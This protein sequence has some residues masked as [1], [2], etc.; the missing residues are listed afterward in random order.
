MI[1]F[2]I[3]PYLTSSQ[4]KGELLSIVVASL[5]SR[6]TDRI[7][8]E[9]INHDFDKRKQLLDLFQTV[10]DSCNYIKHHDLS[11][12][13]EQYQGGYVIEELSRGAS[14]VNIPSN[15]RKLLVDFLKF[16]DYI[17]E[18]V[19]LTF[20]SPTELH[21]KKTKNNTDYLVRSILRECDVIKYE[22]LNNTT[23]I[24]KIGELK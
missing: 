5:F 17:G 2:K 3:D 19:Q 10:Y 9:N 1:E 18:D 6:F 14:A 11:E 24:I 8:N 13:T 23:I 4:T 12:P 7:K 22:E 16:M 21:S 15:F 20:E